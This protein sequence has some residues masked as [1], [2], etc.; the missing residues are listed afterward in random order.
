MLRSSYYLDMY[1]HK[2]AGPRK[3]ML[4]S[5][6][7]KMH[8]YISI[9]T[10]GNQLVPHREVDCN[11][12]DNRIIALARRV[13]FES[14]RGVRFYIAF[15]DCKAVS[16]LSYFEVG[17]CWLE[18]NKQEGLSAPTLKM[19]LNK[20][21]VLFPTLCNLL[22]S[23]FIVDIVLIACYLDTYAWTMYLHT[24]HTYWRSYL[25]TYL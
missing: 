10:N 13:R 16:F 24:A 2:A 23:V 18:D 12:I 20:I 6:A 4:I 15:I 7:V 25:S 17:F 9:W 8:N 11:I 14:R 21:I 3:I 22:G 1:G 19:L 5:Y